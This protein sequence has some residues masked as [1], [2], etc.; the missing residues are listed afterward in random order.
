MRANRT[1]L[2]SPLAA[3]KPAKP[4]ESGRGQYEF[5]RLAYREP[6]KL[7][8]SVCL[9]LIVG[10]SLVLWIAALESLGVLW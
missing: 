8:A 4:S 10:T 7:S 5:T 2:P 6:E 1:E 3:L 9:Q